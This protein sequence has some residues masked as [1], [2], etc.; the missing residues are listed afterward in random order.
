MLFFRKSIHLF[1]LVVNRG[2]GCSLWALS[3]WPNSLVSSRNVGILVPWW[4]IEPTTIA[5]EGVFLTTGP[6]GM[7]WIRCDIH[8]LHPELL[9]SELQV[10]AFFVL[11]DFISLWTLSTFEMLSVLSNVCHLLVFSCLPLPITLIF[12]SN[13]GHFFL[14]PLHI[15]FGTVGGFFPHGSTPVTFC[16]TV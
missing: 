12:I 2:L 4:Q 8:C 3:L 5:L 9:C 11:S 13:P 1:G 15:L 6:A 16:F 14:S 10:L 7:Y